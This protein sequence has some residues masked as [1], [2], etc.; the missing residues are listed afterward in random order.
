MEDAG[1][2]LLAKALRRH[3]GGCGGRGRGGNLPFMRVSINIGV[4]PGRSKLRSMEP[5]HLWEVVETEIP[6]PADPATSAP[7]AVTT[8]LP[9]LPLLAPPLAES[10]PNVATTATPAV[11]TSAAAA[12]AAAGGGGGTAS[13]ALSSSQEILRR[14]ARISRQSTVGATLDNCASSSVHGTDSNSVNNSTSS[15]NN[16]NNNN[17][18]PYA[19][20][21][22]RRRRINDP[23]SAGTHR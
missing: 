11:A 4:K 2:R 9:S 8:P 5:A 20:T 1:A 16:S 10:P 6:L 19:I 12:T 18:A 21:T 22:R 3:D 15:S 23:T 7:A 17:T 13:V 14:S